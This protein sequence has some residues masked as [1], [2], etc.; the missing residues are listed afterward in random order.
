[1]MF[2]KIENLIQDLTCLVSERLNLTSVA[3]SESLFML[4]SIWWKRSCSSPILDINMC[5]L[6]RNIMNYHAFSHKYLP[7]GASSHRRHNLLASETASQHPSLDVL[8]MT[9]TRAESGQ[10]RPC[11]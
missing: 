6:E 11:K 8:P 10:L 3:P 7:P 1:M 5:M 9:P 4:A 2:E